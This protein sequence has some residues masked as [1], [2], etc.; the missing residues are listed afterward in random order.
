M[1]PRVALFALVVAC[2]PLQETAVAAPA[3]A[4]TP[5]S[6]PSDAAV[7]ARAKE[8]LARMQAGNLD[9]S[10]FDAAMNAAVTPS[11]VRQ[12]IAQI[13]RLGQPSAFVL[14]GIQDVD[15]G[16]TAY[17]YRLTFP[18]GVWNEVFVLDGTGKISGIRF[19]P[20]P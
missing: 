6:T 11:V 12:V 7:M 1:N 4:P 10:Q 16:Y 15:G 20:A 2:L 5:M 3:P 14:V 8:W 19:M 17:V 13:G 9:R 18:S